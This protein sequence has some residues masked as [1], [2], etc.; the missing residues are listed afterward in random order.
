MKY[1][2]L[3]ILNY[4]NEN[5]KLDV[6]LIFFY[7]KTLPNYRTAI[8]PRHNK[9]IKSLINNQGSIIHVAKEF[10]YSV[11][12]MNN[13][14][15]KIQTYMQLQYNEFIEEGK[16]I[17][18]YNPLYN[19]IIDDNK[20]EIKSSKNQIRKSTHVLKLERLIENN[21]DWYYFIQDPI[22]RNLV[23]LLLNGED[24]ISIEKKFG[25][26]REI[27]YRKVFKKNYNSVF[28]ILTNK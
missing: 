21:P 17:S 20:E 18:K 1:T 3:E 26:Q 19:Y 12:S 7:I 16:E 6:N 25:I 14:L 27:V 24:Y 4:M 9:F 22:Q 5:K 10:E 2:E 15:K 23:K 11:N 28:D 8:L 13:I